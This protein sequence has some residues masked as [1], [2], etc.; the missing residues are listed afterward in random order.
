M[1][2]YWV[3]IVLGALAVFGVGML[4]T[5]VI[6]RVKHVATSA[7]TIEFPLAFIP[8]RVNDTALG[9]LK[10]VRIHRAAPDTVRGVDLRVAV[11]DSL[12]LTR[13]RDCILVIRD[14][15][16]LDE[17]STFECASPDDTVGADLV[18]FG[19]IQMPDLGEELPFLLP[20]AAAGPAHASDDA[21]ERAAE[22][23][24]SIADA[25]DERA[26]SIA[27]AAEMLADSL[28]TREMERADS[29]RSEGM[30]RADSVRAAGMRVSAR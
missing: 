15:E 2:N 11:H 23:G 25:I 7:E 14:V 5:A 26:D 28:H 4:V 22:Y 18:A 27:D 16:R 17:H 13:L 9:D 8:F 10:R 19:T 21:W 3:K 20:R 29:I 30:R 24:D 6:R 12:S 1:R